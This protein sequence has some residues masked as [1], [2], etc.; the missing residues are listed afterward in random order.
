MILRSITTTEEVLTMLTA[1]KLSADKTSKG[2]FN[3]TISFVPE[4]LSFAPD[5]SAVLEEVNNMMEG[6]FGGGG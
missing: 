6:G 3:T 2:V 1:P 5:H 4:G